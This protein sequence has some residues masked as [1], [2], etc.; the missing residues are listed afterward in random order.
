MEVQVSSGPSMSMMQF[1]TAIDFPAMRSKLLV[2]W[3]VGFFVGNLV[4]ADV[5]AAVGL[6]TGIEVK[7]GA[8]VA[9]MREKRNG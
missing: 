6:A 2:G 4:G 3:L 5:G 8:G 1:G 7:V 9:E